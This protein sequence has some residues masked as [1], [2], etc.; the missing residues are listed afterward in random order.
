MA[1][2]AEFQKEQNCPAIRDGNLIRYENGAIHE[3][4]PYGALIDP[5]RDPLDLAKNILRYRQLDHTAAVSRFRQKKDEILGPSI[6]A[7]NKRVDDPMGTLVYTA[8]NAKKI[9]LDFKAVVDEKSRLLDDAKE[10]VDDA[11]PGYIKHREESF[12]QMKQ[13]HQAF[14][15]EVSKIEI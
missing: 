1:T 2:A 4:V 14:L 12:M 11:T 5:P 13:A 10:A 6:C 3:A 9:L 8:E 7:M 15:D